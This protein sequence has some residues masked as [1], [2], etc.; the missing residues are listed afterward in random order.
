MATLPA[1]TS[2]AAAPQKPP[3]SQP[4][5]AL[6]DGASVR[7]VAPMPGDRLAV[8]LYR[9]LQ[10]RPAGDLRHVLD[11]V[12]ALGS[13]AT[14]GLG[15]A[16]ADDD[17]AF[18]AAQ[19]A[20]LASLTAAASKLGRPPTRRQY[21]TW[22][23]QQADPSAWTPATTIR[24]L[25]GDGSWEVAARRVG[26]LAPDVAAHRLLT[27]GRWFS[28]EE[29]RTAARM[30]FAARPATAWTQRAYRKWAGEYARDPGPDRV[31]LD[32]TVISERLRLRWAELR[33]LADL[34]LA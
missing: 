17:D 14:C 15:A 34:G 22:R 28:P 30:F 1:S 23:S 20:A 27:G 29:C 10:D 25:L 11:A 3:A 6:S 16:G 12:R 8:R 9:L 5:H 33:E 26:R 2:T 19:S 31:P 7:V 13:M 24:R 21:D 4:R 18:D 32:P